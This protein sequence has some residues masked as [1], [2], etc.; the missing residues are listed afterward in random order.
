MTAMGGETMTQRHEEVGWMAMDSADL[1]SVAVDA[2]SEM[3]T[4]TRGTY[5]EMWQWIGN[6]HVL[7][8]L[9]VAA[10]PDD[11][12]SAAGTR[13]RLLA[14]VDRIRGPLDLAPDAEWPR[15]ETAYVPGSSASFLAQVDGVRDGIP[16]S[17]T[18]L[19]AVGSHSTYLLHVAV[20]D[21]ER[22]RQLASSIASSLR[23]T[24]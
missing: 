1:G 9:I 22:G 19:V 3:P 4:Y 8:S 13:H 21:T 23:L 5:G 11:A 20:T 17:N 6:G 24:G 14:E 12:V 18:V 16:V 10:R 2:P 15:T 7:L